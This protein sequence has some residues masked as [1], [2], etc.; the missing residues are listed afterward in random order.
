MGPVTTPAMSLT[1]Q[2]WVNVQQSLPRTAMSPGQPGCR[3][4]LQCLHVVGHQPSINV[5]RPFALAANPSAVLGCPSAW[6][7][8]KPDAIACP[9]IPIASTPAPPS[10]GR[11]PDSVVCPSAAVERAV[12][13]PHAA[14]VS[15]AM[16]GCAVSCDRPYR[17]KKQIL[18]AAW[19]LR[20]PQI[21]AVQ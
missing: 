5:D 8:T 14:A 13:S 4:S 6:V 17:R 2:P 1:V 10:F 21:V 11:P 7:V 20:L 15:A 3:S 18:L 9:F 16:L 12:P 19:N